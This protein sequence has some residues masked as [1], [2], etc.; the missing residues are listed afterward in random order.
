MFFSSFS[1]SA[2]KFRTKQVCALGEKIKWHI[3]LFAEDA[4][5]AA[6]CG[7]LIFLPEKRKGTDR[8]V[9]FLFI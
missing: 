2:R 7:L 3:S 1:P 8:S 5:A 6:V 4:A 9:P